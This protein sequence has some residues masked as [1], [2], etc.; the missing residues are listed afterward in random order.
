M[1]ASSCYRGQDA[2]SSVRS[3]AEPEKD[4]DDTAATHDDENDVA[5]LLAAVDQAVDSAANL[6]RAPDTHALSDE[7]DEN[8]GLSRHANVRR[9]AA[10]L[11]DLEETASQRASQVWNVESSSVKA[12]LSQEATS[13]VCN[14][15]EPHRGV[16]ING[17]RAPLRHQMTVSVCLIFISLDCVQDVARLITIFA[18]AEYGA[19]LSSLQT[20]A[21]NAG[22]ACTAG[23]AQC[24]AATQPVSQQ[25]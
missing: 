17:E 11:D 8:W 13:S 1:L 25:H 21:R 15:A 22:A 24:T 18:S 3:E 10:A 7:Q 12:G 6:D 19:G 5:A 23:W 4:F 16:S 14:V 2:S 9:V 20:H